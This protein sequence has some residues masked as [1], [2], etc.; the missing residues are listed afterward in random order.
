MGLFGGGEVEGFF[1][2]CAGVFA[3]SLLEELMFEGVEFF[4]GDA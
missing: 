2:D 1:L 3:A 4:L